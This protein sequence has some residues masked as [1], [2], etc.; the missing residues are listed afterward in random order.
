MI[1]EYSELSHYHT[2]MEYF[3]DKIT[4]QTFDDKVKN[5][6]LIKQFEIQMMNGL[7]SQG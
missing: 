6:K 3:G 4:F 7:K 2:F 5:K 1:N